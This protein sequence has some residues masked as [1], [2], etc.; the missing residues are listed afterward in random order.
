MNIGV[1]NTLMDEGDCFRKVRDFGADVCQLVSWDHSQGTEEMAAN[2]V[3]H[4]R[5]AG[6]RIAAVWAGLPPPQVW[7]FKEGPVTLGIVPQA[8]RAERLEVLRRWADFA[9]RI[10]APAIITHCGFIPENMTDPEY[11]E[12][13]EAIREIASYCD[14]LGIGFWLETGQETPVVLLR[15]IEQVGLANVGINLDPANL[16][17]YGKGNPV[18]ALDVFGPYVR[19]VHVKDGLYPTNG[20]LLGYEVQVGQGKVNF[21]AFLRRLREVGFDSDLII[22]REI[23]GEEQARDIR[24]TVGL[25]ENWLAEISDETR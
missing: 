7:D 25:L 16:I 8:Y 13:I 3:R 22:E 24:E 9:S 19:N 11:P 15:T 10:E 5:A 2:V 1:L 21:P 23:W 6:V 17:M 4:S 18:D 12:V 20:D 14:K